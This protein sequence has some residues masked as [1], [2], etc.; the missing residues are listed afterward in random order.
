MY[1]NHLL[2]FS[3]SC[4]SDG[5]LNSVW[6]TTI[7]TLP[8]TAFIPARNY[9]GSWQGGHTRHQ[10]S[11]TRHKHI[12]RQ[13]PTHTDTHRLIL[14]VATRF[15][16]PN[17]MQALVTNFQ[18]ASFTLRV[19]FPK[20]TLRS[21]WIPGVGSRHCH[22]DTKAPAPSWRWSCSSSDA[23]RLGMCVCVRHWASVR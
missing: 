9:T 17:S 6:S 1:S 10:T 16:G 13:S 11:Y 18:K 22:S 4:S 14:H 8:Q 7:P 15:K 20:P 19:L 12:T 2:S 21:Y 23:V 3:W 5:T